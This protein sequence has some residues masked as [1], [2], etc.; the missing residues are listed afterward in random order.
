[1]QS[2]PAGTKFC[3]DDKYMQPDSKHL[4]VKLCNSYI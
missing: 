2:S 1:M 3:I 4:L